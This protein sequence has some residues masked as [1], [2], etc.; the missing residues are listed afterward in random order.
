MEMSIIIRITIII[1][2]IKHKKICLYI[3]QLAY[4]NFIYSKNTLIIKFIM[5]VLRNA[6]I[7]YALNKFINGLDW[8]EDHTF[9]ASYFL[10]FK[11]IRKGN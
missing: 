11:I 3:V 4:P 9:K 10:C 5:N 6:L 8:W 7:N 1:I 2:A